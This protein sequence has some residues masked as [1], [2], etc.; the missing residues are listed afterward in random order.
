MPA[1]GL[2][3]VTLLVGC[4]SAPVT[5]TP[6]EEAFG[7]PEE[8]S[9]TPGRRSDSRSW[10]ELHAA[11]FAFSDAL[12]AA[13]VGIKRG[14][15]M[16]PAS[17]VAWQAMLP[18]VGRL[19]ARP[20]ENT[21]PFDLARA[22]LV[23]QA[24]LAADAQLYGD[25]PPALADAAQSSLVKLSARLTDAAPRLRVDVRRFLWPIAPVVVTSP[26][27]NRVHPINGGYRFHAGLDLMAELAQPVRAAYDGTVVYSGWNGAYGKEVELQ[28]DPHLATR[29]GHLLSVLVGDGTRV[30]RGDV[31]GLA[32]STGSS[33]GVHLH[34]ELLRD[35][36]AEDPEEELPA[37]HVRPAPP[38]VARNGTSPGFPQSSSEPPRPLETVTASP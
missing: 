23:L 28:H 37:P 5:K 36:Q 31:I 17:A 3:C 9:P 19:L 25:F 21:S 22:R 13:R 29:Y 8:P 20:L 14:E 27:G 34:F 10:P 7:K 32:G 30:R 24:E 16:A 1:R 33:T 11:L 38:K 12:A 6:W 2:V 15:K 35:G 26:F 18:Q 4:A